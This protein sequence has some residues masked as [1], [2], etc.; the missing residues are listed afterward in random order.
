MG[1]ETVAP[2]PAD[3]AGH[4]VGLCPDLH[5]VQPAPDVQ[6]GFD[7]AV[8]TVTDLGARVEEV[9]LPG[10]ATLFPT[11][12][13]IQRAEAF[14]THRDAGLFPSRSDEYGD[15]VRGRLELGA[16][17]TLDEYLEATTAR[18]HARASMARI[19][20]SVDLLLTPVAACSPPLI[21]Q[22]RLEHGGREMDFRELAM[23]YTVPQDLLGLPAC[24][25]RAGF[26]ELGIPIGV[27]F[28]G[29]RW[30]DVATL[31][32]AHA[33]AAATPELQRR[34]PAFAPRRG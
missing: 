20:R 2:L 6:A 16:K 22:E 29:P 17:T 26:D 24:T 32:A 34:W 21:G 30:G 27:Q 11:F 1:G 3:L 13:V 5:F 8:R 18:E 4:T 33:F 25:V 14:R 7:D 19:F 12:G 23:P 10:A 31:A 28:T 9:S 15:D